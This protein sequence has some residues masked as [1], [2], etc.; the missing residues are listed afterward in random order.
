MESHRIRW[1]VEQNDKVRQK[2]NTSSKFD[3]QREKDDE[4]EEGAEDRENFYGQAPDYAKQTT[5][6]T[7]RKAGEHNTKGAGGSCKNMLVMQIT[8]VL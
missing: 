1:E 6:N 4:E 7:T 3:R 8:T 2:T 5:Y